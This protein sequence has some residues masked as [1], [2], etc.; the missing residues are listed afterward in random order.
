MIVICMP[1]SISKS[2]MTGINIILILS[3]N[4]RCIELTMDKEDNQRCYYHYKRKSNGTNKWLKLQYSQHFFLLRELDYYW[5]MIT[6]SIYSS[7]QIY[8]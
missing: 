1:W 7:L 4:I 6:V 2:F 3:T 8:T 5:L